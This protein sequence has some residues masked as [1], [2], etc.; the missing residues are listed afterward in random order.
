M[1]CAAGWNSAFWYWVSDWD[2][3]LWDLGYLAFGQYGVLLYT[4]VIIVLGYSFVDSSHDGLEPAPGHA[5]NARPLLPCLSDLREY[6]LLWFM[7]L[8]SF[9]CLFLRCGLFSFGTVPADPMAYALREQVVMTLI[10][11]I[12]F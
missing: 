3:E 4:S 7:Q 12:P 2:E 11:H 5:L 6:P 8:T 9:R 1:H 10:W